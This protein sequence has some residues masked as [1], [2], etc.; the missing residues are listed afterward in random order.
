MPRDER[1][2]AARLLAEQFQGD[3]ASAD[4]SH[5]G[6]LAGFTNR[7]REHLAASGY[8]FVKCVEARGMDA[9]RSRPFREWARAKCKAAEAARI[10]QTRTRGLEGGGRNGSPA[11]IYANYFAEWARRVEANGRPK[12]LSRGDFAVACRMLKE[13][14]G[15]E[16]IASA[17]AM[18]SPNIEERKDKHIEDYTSRTV[19]SA[20]KI[21]NRT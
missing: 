21:V 7:K 4:A 9:E 1:K 18:C 12:D 15:V 11:A 17:M 20:M 14:H 19:L 5:F 16:Q 13:G 10:Q 8:P 2:A 6:R 3:M